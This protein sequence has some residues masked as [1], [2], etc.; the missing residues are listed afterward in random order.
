MDP[1]LHP[2]QLYS[3]RCA[4]VT[5]ASKGIG[6]EIVRRLAGEEGMTVVLTARDVK[7]G[8][9]A[10]AFSTIRVSTTC[11]FID[12]TFENRRTWKPSPDSSEIGSGHPVIKKHMY[13]VNNAGVS[14][15]WVDVAGLKALNIDPESW[16]S[17]KATD[18][19]KGIIRQSYEDAKQCLDTNFYGCRRVTEALL[20][21][22]KLSPSARI[23]NV[24]SLRSELKRIPNEGIRCEFGDLE[25]LDEA[26]IDSL[27]GRFLKDLEAGELE[28]GRW[29]RMLPAY[30]MSKV[31][32]NAY[33]RVLARRHPGMCINCVHPGYVNTDINW[34]TGFLTIEEGARGPVMLSLLSDDG[35]SGKYFDQTVVSEF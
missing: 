31:A 9:E 24:S 11:C 19:V 29:P 18:S 33:T 15:V 32:L 3:G 7:R 14:G 6:L 35:P 1:K 4:V 34:H 22:L 30:S 8:R 20:P 16:L 5:G 27:L 12:W 17:G 2:T 25:G 23:V 10:V 26:K 28:K 21:L 13:W